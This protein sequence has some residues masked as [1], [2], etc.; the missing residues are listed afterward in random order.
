M[1]AADHRSGGDA[2]EGLA[3]LQDSLAGAFGAFTGTQPARADV[4]LVRVVYF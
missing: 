4:T 3:A 1:T 2:P